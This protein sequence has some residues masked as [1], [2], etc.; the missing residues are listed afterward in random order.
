MDK[1]AKL[2]CVLLIISLLAVPMVGCAKPLTLTITAP[3]NGTTV[4]KSPVEVRANVSDAKATVWVNDSIVTVKKYTKGGGW[5]STEVDLNEGENI[6]K[7]IAARGYKKG[8]WKEVVDRTVTVTY[9][10]G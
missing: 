5:F 7:V 1:L 10:P 6:I 9:S 3:I 8:T 2:V 4:N